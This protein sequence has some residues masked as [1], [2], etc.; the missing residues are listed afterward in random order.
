MLSQCSA[1]YN[2][3]APVITLDSFTPAGNR[4]IDIGAAGPNPFTFTVTT[5]VTWLKTSVTKGSVS[6]NNSEQRVFVTPDWSHISGTET[7]QIS[8]TATAAN[9]PPLTQSVTFTATK[10][11]VPNGFKGKFNNMGESSGLLITL[12]YRLR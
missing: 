4:F 9:Q 8:F 11:A 5:N 3:P 12:F 6:A 7:A 1:G 2:C 10:L